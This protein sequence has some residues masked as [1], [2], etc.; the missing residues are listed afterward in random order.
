MR[1]F[2]PDASDSMPAATRPVV[3][4]V[5]SS[6]W[7]TSKRT[8]AVG[9][10]KVKIGPTLLRLARRGR[11]E[12]FLSGLP[13]H[14]RTEVAWLRLIRD[15]ICLLCGE[16]VPSGEGVITPCF[17][18]CYPWAIFHAKACFDVAKALIKDP[19]DPRGLNWRSLAAWRQ[20]IDTIW[21][22][23]VSAS[24]IT[25]LLTSCPSR[26][27][28]PEVGRRKTAPSAPSPCRAGA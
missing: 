20:A 2:C 21:H 17:T 11:L 12:H 16:S 24:R 4:S 6:G 23:R 13:P 19:A 22:S 10:G 25:P 7:E 1:R 26:W 14:R 8:R 3:S 28:L 5:R 9:N 15:H 27:G 18:G